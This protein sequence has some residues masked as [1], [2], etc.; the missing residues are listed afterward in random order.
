[1]G[2][3]IRELKLQNSENKNKKTG[4]K[5]YKNLRKKV[6][7]IWEEKLQKLQKTRNK[8]LGTKISKIQEQK[9][10]IREQNP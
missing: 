9:L 10:I 5:S 8:N 4:N 7:K 2:T 1:L 6:T 3:K